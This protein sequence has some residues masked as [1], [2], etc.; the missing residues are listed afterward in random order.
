MSLSG[1]SNN[2]QAGFILVGLGLYFVEM[3]NF[4]NIVTLY[5]FIDMQRPGNL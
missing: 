5:A 4:L 1:L 3:I 2:G